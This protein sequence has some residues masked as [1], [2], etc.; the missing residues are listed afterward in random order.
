MLKLPGLCRAV[1]LQ[2]ALWKP[3]GWGPLAGLVLPDMV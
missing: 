1:T 3:P 2:A